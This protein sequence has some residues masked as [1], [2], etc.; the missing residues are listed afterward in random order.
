ML[1]FKQIVI[2]VS[3]LE[4]PKQEG[5]GVEDVPKEINELD[6]SPKSRPRSTSDRFNR[7]PSKK[8]VDVYKQVNNLKKI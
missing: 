3:K 5:A 6:L 1:I 4:T 2:L 7:Q 8:V